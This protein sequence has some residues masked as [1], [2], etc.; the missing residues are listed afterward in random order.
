MNILDEEM[1][2]K[3]NLFS[4]VLLILGGIIFFSLLLYACI[5]FKSTGTEQYDP[6]KISGISF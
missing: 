5:R 1:I 2:A 4:A 3:G 6:K